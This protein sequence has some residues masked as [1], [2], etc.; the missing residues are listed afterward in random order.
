[1]KWQDNHNGTRSTLV[2]DAGTL[3][4][5]VGTCRSGGWETCVTGKWV[6]R[7]TREDIQ[8]FVE[9]YLQGQGRELIQRE[10]TW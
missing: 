8:R 5:S 4:T 9:G 10:G 1:M 3:I 2:S 6:F 7:L